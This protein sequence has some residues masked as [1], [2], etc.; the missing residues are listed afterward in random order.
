MNFP[1]F[2]KSL[3][4]LHHNTENPRAYFTVYE[5]EESALEDIRENSAYFTGLN[6]NWKFRYYKSF[7][8]VGDDFYSPSYACDGLNTVTVPGCWQLY[9]IEGTDTPLYSNLMYPFPTDPPHV[10]DENPCAAY[11]RDFTAE[12]DGREKILTFEGVASCFYVFINGSFAGYSQISHSTSEFNITEYLKSGVNRIAVLVVKWCDGSYLEDQDFFRLSG[13]FRDV[14]IL[15]RNKTRI[16]DIFIKESFVPDFSSATLEISL[17]VNGEAGAS[18]KLLD[19]EGNLLSSNVFS[20][21]EALTVIRDPLLWNDEQPYLYTLIIK[22]A[23]EFIPLDIAMRQVSIEDR[24]LLINGKAVKLRGINRHDSSAEH[25]YTVTPEEMLRD[26][27]LMKKANVNAIRTSHYPNDPRFPLMAQ[28]L[29]FYLIDEADIETHGMGYNTESDWDWMRW[30]LLSTADEWEEAYVDRT[31]HLYER[32]KNVGAVI[33]WSLG[34]ESGCGKNHRKMREYIKGRD[35]NALVHYEN[36]HLQFTA[37]PEGE[38]FADISDVESRMYPSLEYTKEYLE[39]PEYTKP[40]YMCEYVSSMTTGD[41]YDFWKLI[42]SYD[43]F[44]GG[45]IWE[46]SDHSVNIPDENGSARYYYGG[47]F[48]DFPNDGIC[49]IDGLV[50]PDRTPRPGYYDMKKVYEVFRGE[51]ND[52]RVI[53]RNTRYFTPLTDMY[54]IWSLAC[55]GKEI[56][57]GTVDCVDVA[58][59]SEKEFFLF[60]PSDVSV[61]GNCFLTLSFRQKYDAPW[62]EAGF[63]TGFLQFELSAMTAVAEKEKNPVIS[64]DD[65][66]YIRISCGVNEYVFDRSYGRID[67]IRCKGR[68]LLESPSAFSIVH[69]PT[70]NRGSVDAWE[71]NHFFNAVQKT[72]SAEVK[73]T[74]SGCVITTHIALGGPANPPVVKAVAEYRFSPDGG[75][76]ISVSGKIRENVP[77]LPRLGIELRLDSEIGNIRWL[78]LGETESYPDRYKACRFGLWES[79]ADNNFVHY[80][81]PQENSSH[82][83]TRKLSIY[84]GGVDITV[85]PYGMKDFSF[86]ASRYSVKRLTETAHDF[87]LE[88]ENA[89]VINLDGRFNSISESVRFDCDGNHIVFDDKEFSFGFTIIPEAL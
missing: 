16:E 51:H 50:F 75:V 57:S 81:R 40:F 76:N 52:G 27:Y 49:C 88:K 41:V 65:G 26:L 86:N 66:R 60:N 46:W 39:N 54:F 64:K 38:N 43:N 36:A 83:K 78:G 63:E 35:K 44:C 68:E 85:L 19:P 21:N 6:G 11:I 12:D 79:S 2:H 25:G 77:P 73:N 9:G 53:I 55:D 15:S 42:D 24:K 48:G 67:S 72:Y 5:S 8:D 84:G 82:Y 56:L 22:C 47:D 58:P 32:D 13:I 30:S 74:E 80:I 7:E 10:P 33:M 34:N 61:Y 71:A 14:Y 59:Q 69:A 17:T 28:R 62:A 37:V 89:A 45:C 29:G 31:A 70:Y 3:E 1:V 20:D 23:D 87:E 4:V 18:Y